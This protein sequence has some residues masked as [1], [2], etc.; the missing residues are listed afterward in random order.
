MLTYNKIMGTFTSV[1]TLTF[2]DGMSVEPYKK[3]QMYVNNLV[4]TLFG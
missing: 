4:N 1:N 2:V 3:I